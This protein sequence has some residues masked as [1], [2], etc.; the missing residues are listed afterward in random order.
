MLIVQY[1]DGSNAF[2]S[3]S[4][5]D[6]VIPFIVEAAY[7][8]G[9]E[10]TRIISFE[11]ERDERR[12]KK[13]ANEVVLNPETLQITTFLN[14]ETPGEYEG[15]PPNVTRIEKDTFNGI[16]VYQKEE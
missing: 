6:G 15:D 1:L 14:A 11:N 9:N 4:K 10:V 8:N 13:T 3:N 2:H 7:E 12:F 16:V 5:N